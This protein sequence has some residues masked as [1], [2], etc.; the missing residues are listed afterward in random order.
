MFE[1]LIQNLSLFSR[2]HKII[3]SN[4]NYSFFNVSKS[5]ITVL[6]GVIIP[7][8]NIS[9]NLSDNDKET[10]A[11][12]HFTADE[13]ITG[14]VILVVLMLSALIGNVLTCLIIWKKPSFRTTTNISILFL[15]I[16]DILMACFVM[17]FSVASLIR[18]RWSFSAEA[19]TFTAFFRYHLIGVSLFT[20]TCTAVIRYLCVV[21]PPLHHQYVKPKIVTFVISLS[22]VGYFIVLALPIFFTSTNVIYDKNRTLCIYIFRGQGVTKTINFSVLAG[23]FILGSVIFL[24]YFKVFRFVSHHNHTMA[25]NLQQPSTLHVEETKIT[26]TLV[27]VVLGFVFCWVPTTVI[28]CIAIFED[29]QFDQSRMPNFLF[30]LQTMCLF[31]SSAINPFIYGFTSKRFRKRYFELLGFLRP[32]APQIAPVGIGNS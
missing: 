29:S 26:K 17:P 12:E 31:T 4:L 22:W 2:C 30:L 24:A 20:M 21:K 1:H 11:T 8:M 23:A 16:S 14:S 9:G 28:Q 27:I 32:S 25:S 3:W 7:I 18:G 10:K 6:F 5:A 13:I 15:S 19:C